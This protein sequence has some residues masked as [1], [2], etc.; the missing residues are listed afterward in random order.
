M[1]AEQALF[2]AYREWRRLAKA[3]SKAISLKDW[4]LLAECQ[5]LLQNI[6]PVITRLTQE[7]HD[8]W[9]KSGADLE[10]KKAKLRETV[11]G[12]IG[13]ARENQLSLRVAREL[14]LAKGRQLAEAGRNL[15]R[16]QHSYAPARPSGWMSFS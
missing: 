1:S 7:A 15:K 8:E 5:N 3:E 9:E 12:L 13:L 4:N 16:L 10:A 14:M 2:D 6:Q 11:A